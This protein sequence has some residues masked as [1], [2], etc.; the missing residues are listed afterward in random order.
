MDSSASMLIRV[1]AELS[2]KMMA[3]L[4]QISSHASSLDFSPD[5]NAIARSNR[6]AAVS[7]NDSA[8]PN[9]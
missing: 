9:G 7:I 6:T 4:V 8:D 5:L 1:I 2:S 3:G